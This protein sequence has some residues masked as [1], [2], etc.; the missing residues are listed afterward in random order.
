MSFL[1]ALALVAVPSNPPASQAQATVPSASSW[2]M[3]DCSY[4]SG[5]LAKPYA[6]NT[7]WL[8]FTQAEL[9]SGSVVTKTIGPYTLKMKLS[10]VNYGGDKGTFI[11]QSDRV[12]TDSAFGDAATSQRVFSRNSG[13]A[14]TPIIVKST[15]NPNRTRYL[16]LLAEDISLTKKGQEQDFGMVFADGEATAQNGSVGELLSILSDGSNGPYSRITPSGYQDA[17]TGNYKNDTVFGPGNVVKP[18]EW[19]DAVAGPKSFACRIPGAIH[20]PPERPGTWVYETRN[21]TQVRVGL[22]GYS[23]S[24]QAFVMGINMSRVA[25]P[26]QPV[27]VDNQ[28]L[29]NAATRQ[30]TTFDPAGMSVY[31]RQ[32]TVDTPIPV[33]EGN[34]AGVIRAG[35]P[36]AYTDSVVYRSAAAGDQKALALDR[37]IPMWT[38]TLT[39]GGGSGTSHTFTSG[40]EPSEL[41]VKVNN[42]K[43]EGWSEVVVTDPSGRSPSCSVEWKSRFS[44]AQ[45]Q[46]N[47]T[48]DGSAQNFSALQLRSFDLQYSC[49][50]ITVSDTRFSTAYPTVALTKTVTLQRGQSSTVNTLPLGAQC[51]V[52]ETT[53][54]NAPPPGSNLDLQWNPSSTPTSAP[55]N[56]NQ[57]NNSYTVRVGTTNKVNAYNRY[58][59]AT[60][61]LTI[62]KETVGAPVDDGF[63]L[64]P[65]KFELICSATNLGRQEVSLTLTRTGTSVGGSVRVDNVP[66]G[67]D[68]AVRPL[69]DLTEQQK[70][71]VRFDGRVVTFGGVTVQPDANAYH[72]TLP[73][74]QGATGE[75]HFRTSYSYN[76]RDI[77]LTKAY[78]GTAANSADLAGLT[79]NVN[80]KCT[81][82]ANRALTGAVTVTT[83][84]AATI[85]DIPVGSACYMWEDTPADTTNTRFVGARF[86]ASDNADSAT[87]VQN[88]HGQTTKLLTVRAT[89]GSDRNSALLT[90][91]FDYRLGTV[92][93]QKIVNSGGVVG[94]LPSTFTM[95]YNC[96]TRNVGNSAISL[97]GTFTVTGGGSTTL[98]S[99]NAAVN[100]QGG[101]MGVPYGNT[102]KF[103]ED[104][105]TLPGG[106]RWSSNVQSASVVVSSATN[107]ATV[108]NTFTPVGDGLTVTQHMGGETY[109]MPSDELSYSLSCTTPTGAIVAETVTPTNDK[110]F[111]VPATTLPKGSQ[112]TIVETSTETSTRTNSNGDPFKISRAMTVTYSDGTNG[113]TAVPLGGV[114]T[115]GDHS[116]L[117]LTAT[118]NYLNSTIKVTKNVVFDATE[119]L[120]SEQ[121][122]QVQRD[123]EYPATLSCILPD[124]SPG[125]S[126]KGTIKRGE[127]I[128]QD[129][130][131]EGSTCS[132]SEDDTTT[133]VGITLTKSILVND[134]E[135]ATGNSAATFVARE[136]EDAVELV[137]TFTRRITSMTVQKVAVMPGN[138]R[139]QYAASKQN[140]QDALYKHNFTLDCRDP[141]T[142]DTAVLSTTTMQI[143]GEESVNF[144]R[145]PVGADCTITG[146]HFGSLKLT[147]TEDGTGDTLNAFLRPQSVDWVVDRTGGNSVF[148]QAL[149]GEKTTSPAVLTVDDAAANHVVLTNHYGYEMAPVALQKT[150]TGRTEDLKLIGEDTRFNFAVQCKA[151]GY[152]TSSLSDGRYTIPSAL[153]K[154]DFASSSSDDN[155]TWTYTSKNV[156]VPAGSLCRMQELLPT[157]SPQELQITGNPSV[158]EVRAPDPGTTDPQVF[159]FTNTVTRRTTPVRLVLREDGYLNGASAAGYTAKITC[160]TGG[161]GTIEKTFPRSEVTTGSLPTSN[162]APSSDG[163]VNLP[164]GTDCTISYGDSPALAAR[165]E[166]EVTAGNRRPFMRFAR[167]ENN[168][169]YGGT[170]TL[171]DTPPSSVADKTYTYDFKVAPDAPSTAD[172]LVIGASFFHPRATYDVAFTKKSEGEAGE[173]KTFT[174]DA[175]CGSKNDEFTLT[176]GKTHKIQGVPVG[177]SCAVTETDDGNDK[178]NPVMSVTDTGAFIDA[179]VNAA[180]DGDNSVSFT[181]LPTT[182]DDTSRSGD[183]WSLTALNRFPGMKVEKKIAGTP[184]SAVTGAVIDRAILPDNA[185][186]MD[187]TY[188]VTNNGAFDVSNIALKE[189]SLIGRTVSAAPSGATPQAL[190]GG[191]AERI[192][193]VADSG[194]VIGPDGLIPSSACSVVGASLKPSESVSC[195]VRVDISNEPKDKT[196]SYSGTV[197]AT[198][199]AN[200]A[201]VQGGVEADAK[202]GALRLTGIIGALLPDTG[203]QT[204][205]LLLLLGLLIFGYGAWRYLRRDDEVD[206][207][208][209]AEGG[210][211]EMR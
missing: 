169:Y 67:Q 76:L 184:V 11:T 117:S 130:V 64:S 157:S 111:N 100:D 40:S 183:K 186:Y 78:D 163:I 140:L 74:R 59:Y 162:G 200:G 101:A 138:V 53:A 159:S 196:F 14:K 208:H 174:F 4:R 168:N 82:P 49:T 172:T 12:T 121:R 94:T 2:N 69:T 95:R 51:T 36:G 81:T 98:T 103:E 148:D 189:E 179:K 28:D 171:S 70:E 211:H 57:G 108:T 195:T 65:Y 209:A 60:G 44:P 109:L 91:T 62:S 210:R 205:V 30:K 110:E 151:I 35:S 152:Q 89:S 120:I 202:Y 87:V 107:S 90:N 99:T 7:C 15:A 54:S 114:F 149:K 16:E 79:F 178:V 137:N 123:R 58:D 154:S 166:V 27:K 165:G 25:L 192:A 119:D 201:S 204:L 38:C 141:E 75:L 97:Q 181:V 198:A 85:K 135:Q 134:K 63:N 176:A 161:A 167:W 122:K 136:G 153:G 3:T 145:V 55:S 29:E 177:S 170:S 61:S 66:V 175:N 26:Q 187:I 50:D 73:A 68:C 80:Y 37:Y 133:A 158:A 88:S 83:A 156:P 113:T 160:K 24:V 96:G 93:V 1:V 155:S 126:L 19:P 32:G 56:P 39:D 47:K 144:P 188:T 34:T 142:G 180:N 22:G 197:E 84:T 112:C 116:T 46:L 42:N 10:V 125:V 71:Q 48:V 139:E 194:V 164:V 9:T 127:V 128:T 190:V 129:N 115:I 173:G 199:T 31:L 185:A 106:V 193:L 104:Q 118:Y 143:K 77:T 191:N 124:G 21:P 43:S 92:S 18:I 23:S 8:S 86:Q 131:P 147:M 150:T 72:F 132:V 33:T 206:P 13:D 182:K 17:C 105:P 45:L 5:D 41:P 203:Q 207:E 146:D 52:T 20:D 6:G 102:C